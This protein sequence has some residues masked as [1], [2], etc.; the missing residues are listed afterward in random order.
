VYPAQLREQA[1]LTSESTEEVMDG[2]SLAKLTLTVE[3]AAL[4]EIIAKGEL[5]K[6]ADAVATQ[7]AAQISAQIAWHVAEVSTR[8][9]EETSDRLL[10]EVSFHEVF[11]DGEPGFGTG[12]FPPRPVVS[13]KDE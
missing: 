7:A 4:R 11:V 12:R 9:P 3:P 2:K 8:P 6:F 13:A 10:A 1:S 5:L